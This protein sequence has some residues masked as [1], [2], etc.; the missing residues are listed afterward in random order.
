MV[1]EAR[2][3]ALTDSL[4][5]AYGVTIDQAR[6]SRVPSPVPPAPQAAGR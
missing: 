5:K 1:R 3:R 6:L 2:L 4:E